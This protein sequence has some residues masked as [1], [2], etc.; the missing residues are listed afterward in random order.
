[1]F[2]EVIPKAQKTP[3]LETQVSIDSNEIFTNFN[4]TDPNLG[5]S[6]IRGVAIYVKDNLYFKEVQLKSI[7]DDHVWVEIRLMNGARQRIERKAL[8]M[9][10]TSFLIISFRNNSHLLI[11]GDFNYP[12]IDWECDYVGDSPN[13]TAAF[14]ETIQERYFYQH[15]FEPTRFRD[16][17]EPGLLDLVL[18]NEEGMV[19]NLTQVRSR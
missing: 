1:M 6:G 7:Y 18:S 3:I 11:C 10:V 14:I 8:K 5:A 2:T 19:Y 13:T 17:H 12:G 16:G 15:I 9:F 4:F